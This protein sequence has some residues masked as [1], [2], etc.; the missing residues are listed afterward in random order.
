M[1]AQA[2]QALQCAGDLA[3]LGYEV[4]VSMKHSIQQ[5]VFLVYG[6]PEFRL[7]KAIVQ[8]EVENLD[9]IMG[10]DSI[11]TNMVIGRVLSIDELYRD[12]L[13]RLYSSAQVQVFHHSWVLR[14]K[15]LVGVYSANEYLTR[16]KPYE[17]LSRTIMRRLS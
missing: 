9:R 15:D 12:G 10:V 17:G 16:I 2:L 6:I 7:P 1:S 14:A 13:S 3:K 5:A 8:K 11:K 4:T